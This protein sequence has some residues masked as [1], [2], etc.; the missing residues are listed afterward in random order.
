MAKMY[1]V[2]EDS[3]D[4]YPLAISEADALLLLHEG[5]IWST[6]DWIEDS[7]GPTTYTGLIAEGIAS[8]SYLAKVPMETIEKRLV[9]YEH[10]DAYFFIP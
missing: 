5:L 8:D 2:F 7:A 1:K 10:V 6:D 3:R 9:H 4:P